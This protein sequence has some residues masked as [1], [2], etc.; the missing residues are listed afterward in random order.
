MGGVQLVRY[1]EITRT[2]V[3]KIVPE[4]GQRGTR[5]GDLDLKPINGTFLPRSKHRALGGS[6]GDKCSD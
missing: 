4:V 3:P 2:L 5:I 1:L 6:F